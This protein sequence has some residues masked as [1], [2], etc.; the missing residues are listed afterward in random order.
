MCV[1]TATVVSGIGCDDGECGVV[2]VVL[3]NDGVIS[4]AMVVVVAVASA[5]WVSLVAVVVASLPMC[6]LSVLALGS[7]C[8]IE[9]KQKAHQKGA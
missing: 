4:A 7:C 6:W 5:L 3:A 9:A 2:A 1:G 8:R